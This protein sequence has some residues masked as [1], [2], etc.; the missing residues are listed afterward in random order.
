[1]AYKITPTEKDSIIERERWK[2]GALSL[3]II[4]SSEWG[5]A[6]VEE[7]PLLDEDYSEDNGI[8]VHEFFVLEFDGDETGIEIECPDELTEEEQEQI[9]EVYFKEF[10]EGLEDLGWRPKD[11]ELIYFGKLEIIEVDN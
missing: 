3:Y 11:T 4:H 7:E 6:I 8:D 2:K 5:H 1:M 9:K 10:D